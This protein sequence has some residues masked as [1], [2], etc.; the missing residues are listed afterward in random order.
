MII[1][2]S[3]KTDIP[4]FYG[5]WFMRRLEEGG[6]RMV[7]PWGGQVHEVPLTT[8]E[9][10]GFVFWTRNLRPFFH[11]LPAVRQRAPFA[12]QYTITGYPRAL[13]PGVVA[14]A[15]AIADLQRL[16]ADFGPRV[17]VWRYD[18][19]LFTSLTPA[20]WHRTQFREIAAA[21]SGTVDEVVVSFA[22]IYAKTRR[23][24]NAASRSD[25]FEW[26]DP[27][28][29]E[30]RSLAVDLAALASDHGMRLTVCA[31][32]NHLVAGAAPARCIDAD[33][34]ADVAGE[35]VAAP[36]KGNRPDCLCH[37]SRDI[38]AYD[39]CPHGCVYCYAVRNRGLA[40]RR[41]QAHDPASPYLFEPAR[42]RAE[43]RDE[44]FAQN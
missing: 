17:G 16:A 24:L 38:G 29:E 40:K 44:A 21:L 3:Y 26:T 22:H 28:L 42:H 11:N 35:A 36:V 19:V 14:T 39:T 23:N 15:H 31:Q 25:D 7:N 12:V 1:S 30:K 6:C 34:L 27:R 10:D 9:V 2:A 37:R 5:K 32:A 43:S 41:H 8:D 33:R 18:P 20:D 4:A 13:E